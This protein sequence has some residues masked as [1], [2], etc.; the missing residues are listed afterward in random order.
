MGGFERAQRFTDNVEHNPVMDVFPDRGV[1]G[2]TPA[3][4]WG[5][6]ARVTYIPRVEH[7]R[8]VGNFMLM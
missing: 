7:T 8:D 5:V 4:L 6:A 2:Y 3:S 1:H